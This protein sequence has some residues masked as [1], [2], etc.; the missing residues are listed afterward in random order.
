MSQ[1]LDQLFRRCRAE[2]RTAFVPYLM[3]GDPD[4][5]ATAAYAEALVAAGADMIEL[6][7]PFS[8]PPADGPVLQRAAERALLAGMTT[9]RAMAVLRQIRAQTQV[10]LSLLCYANPVERYGVAAFYRDMAAAGIDAVLV[11]DVPV[12]EAGDYAAAAR[13]AG[14][15]PVLLASALSTDERLRAVGALGGGYVYATARVGI[16]GEKQDLA[17]DFAATVQRIARGTA[18]PVVVG[19]GLSSPAHLAAVAA[20]GANGAIVG[21][22]IAQHLESARQAGMALADRAQSLRDFAAPLGQACQN[23][24][25]SLSC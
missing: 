21:S 3:I 15:A 17:E 5:E 18:L 9:R 14:I 24:S 8:D 23:P 2:G 16:T 12:E 20:A 7:L 6:G 11:A 1:R 22:A 19:F 10:P 25:R 13:A 4:A